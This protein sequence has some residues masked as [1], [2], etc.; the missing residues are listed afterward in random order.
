MNR[1]GEE[2]LKER[3]RARVLLAEDN[4]ANAALLQSVLQSEFDVVALVGNGRALVAAV[5]TLR[6]DVIVTD[7]EMPELDGLEATRQIL[8]G[9]PDARV[10]LVTVHG[11]PEIVERGWEVGALGYVLK[12]AAG[13]EL[14]LAVRSAL[15]GQRYVSGLGH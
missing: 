1:A 8:R 3:G 12:L 13:D 6:P 5:V 15:R 10:V 11:S 9:D 2:V 14:V 7:I 4:A